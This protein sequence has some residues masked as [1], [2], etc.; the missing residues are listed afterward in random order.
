MINAKVKVFVSEHSHYLENE[1]NSFLQTI[2]IRQVIKTEHSTSAGA[3]G[4]RYTTIIYY[5]DSEDIRDI[6][7]DDVLNIK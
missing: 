2:D 6:R 3:L 5:I 4:Y 1:V 7:I